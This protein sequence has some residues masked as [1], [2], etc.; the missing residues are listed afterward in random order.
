MFLRERPLGKLTKEQRAQWDALNRRRERLESASERYGA[1]ED[2]FMSRLQAQL[3]PDG[4]RAHAGIRLERDGTVYAVFCEC[5]TCQADLNQLSVTA[6]V[7]AMIAAGIIHENEAPGARR[8]A[9]EIDTARRFAHN[10]P[11]IH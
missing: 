11:L 3:D 10:K 6:T 1:A 4:D 7:N 8:H 9:T 5:V 2:K